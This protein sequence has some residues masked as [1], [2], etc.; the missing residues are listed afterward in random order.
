MEQF[1]VFYDPENSENL[2]IKYHNGQKPS[3]SSALDN[4]EVTM[5]ITITYPNG[6]PTS[7]EYRLYT[8][9]SSFKNLDD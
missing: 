1:G 4:T 9:G 5:K 6:T 3:S 7:K 8:A 2:I